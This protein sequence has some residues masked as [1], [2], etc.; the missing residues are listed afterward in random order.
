MIVLFAFGCGR[1]QYY[2]LYSGTCSKLSVVCVEFVTWNNSAAKWNL[3]LEVS[4]AH[5][6]CIW[7]DPLDQTLFSKGTKAQYFLKEQLASS[8][9]W[10]KQSS[11]LAKDATLPPTDFY[12]WAQNAK[13]NDALNQLSSIMGKTSGCDQ[14][15]SMVPK[16]GYCLSIFLPDFIAA[17]YCQFLCIFPCYSPYLVPPYN[18]IFPYFP[19]QLQ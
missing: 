9:S 16:L 4:Q 8:G 1:E 3:G 5:R 17:L 13:W 7:S 12:V 10:R 19:V 2:V 11:G 6:L 14:R 15:C 18:Q